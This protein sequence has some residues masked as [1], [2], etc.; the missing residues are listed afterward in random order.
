MK[1]NA[2]ILLACL[3]IVQLGISQADY[4]KLTLIDGDTLILFTPIQVTKL[5]K[6]FLDLD[7]CVSISG[8]YK[9]EIGLYKDNNSVLQEQI[10]LGNKKAELLRSVIDE[11]DSQVQMLDDELKA[12]TRKVK[13]LKVAG[14]IIGTGGIIGGFIG[15]YYASKLLIR[16]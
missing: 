2:T 13:L 14:G 3:L 7:E 12:S 6:T 1:K 10:R 8:T 4:P 9:Q 15:G 16:Q 5:N 11:K